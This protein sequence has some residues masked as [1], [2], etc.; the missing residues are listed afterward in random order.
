MLIRTTL[1]KLV[2][3]IFYHIFIFTLNDSPSKTIKNVFLFHQKSLFHSLDIQVLVI[4][5]SFPYFP[6]SKG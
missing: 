5:S 1:S 3:A 4:F 6:D 2:S